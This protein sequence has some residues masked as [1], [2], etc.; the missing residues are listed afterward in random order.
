MIRTILIL[1]LAMTSS[2][3][4]AQV[5][6]HHHPVGPCLIQQQQNV[7]YS[8][9]NVFDGRGTFIASY[10]DYNQAFLTAQ[11]YDRMGYCHGI[12]TNFPNQ[13]YPAPRS[14]CQIMQGRDA[15]GNFFYRVIDRVGRILYTTPFYNEAFQVSQNDGRCYQ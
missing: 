11:N 4:L 3:A 15:Y 12:R 7:G 8:V 10:T 9:F 14:Y 1:L 2:S 13:P 5:I 6:P